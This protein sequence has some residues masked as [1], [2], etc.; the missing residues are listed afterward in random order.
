[1][2]DDF[3]R[4]IRKFQRK[5]ERVTSEQCVTFDE[6]FSDDFMLRHTDFPSI[7]ALFDAS[8]FTLETNDDLAAIPEAELDAFVAANT[9]FTSWEE[10][11]S[12]AGSE[13]MARRLREG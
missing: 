1:M 13:W 12:A 6:L 5:L 9:R 7:T 2:V 4:G 11:K 10:M 8:P 3:R